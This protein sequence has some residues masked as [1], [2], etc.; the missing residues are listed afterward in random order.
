MK[1]YIGIGAPLSLKPEENQPVS[2][3]DFEK[4]QMEMARKKA[5]AEAA[6]VAAGA[7]AAQAQ[8]EARRVAAQ[9]VID[10]ENRAEIDAYN[11]EQARLAD[12]A[13]YAELNDMSWDN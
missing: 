9:A 11:A 1:N 13:M 5:V 2:I 10:A 4:N 7:A 6:A 12:E 8:A 3:G